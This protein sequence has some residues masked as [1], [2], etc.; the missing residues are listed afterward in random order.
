MIV[1]LFQLNWT[2]L[3]YSI[4]FYSILFYSILP[5]LTCMWLWLGE[6]NPAA[7]WLSLSLL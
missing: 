4:L 5:H 1:G 2:I 3:F 7:A 6:M